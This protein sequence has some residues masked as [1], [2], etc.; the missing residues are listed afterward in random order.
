MKRLLLI[1][2]M[3][4]LTGC[5]SLK[6]YIPVKW[7]VN[8]SHAITT[9]QQLARNFDCKGNILEQASYL[10]SQIQ[11]FTIYADTKKTR[12][13]I[14][15]VGHMKDT[16]KELVDRSSKGPVSPLYCDLKKK[17]MIQQADMVAHTVQGRLF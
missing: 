11:W 1:L 2:S 10:N 13:V 17:L 7:D 14:E 6:E 15:P 12:D 3:V 9:I 8:Q 4:V 16:V 5:G